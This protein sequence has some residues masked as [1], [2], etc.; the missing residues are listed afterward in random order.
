MTDSVPTEFPRR[1]LV[2]VINSEPHNNRAEVEARYGKVW[3]TQE[4]QSEFDVTG[5]MAPFVGVIRKSDGK[6]GALE[7]THAPRWYFN[8]QEG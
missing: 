5:F 8:F 3:N 4:L 1:V 2:E 7:F 6:K